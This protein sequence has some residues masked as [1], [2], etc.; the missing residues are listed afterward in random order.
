MI[1]GVENGKGCGAGRVWVVMGEIGDRRSVV[2][3]NE[4]FFKCAAS[5]KKIQVVFKIQPNSIV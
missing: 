4:V 1:S 2:N 3:G 5:K